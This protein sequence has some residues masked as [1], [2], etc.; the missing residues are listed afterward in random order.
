MAGAATQNGNTL[1]MIHLSKEQGTILRAAKGLQQ[2]SKCRTNTF[3][4]FTS[5]MQ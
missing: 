5:K 1:L 4:C 2:L 3:T